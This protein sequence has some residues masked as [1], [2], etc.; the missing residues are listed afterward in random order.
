MTVMMTPFPIY[1]AVYHSLLQA[2][3]GTADIYRRMPTLCY[4]LRRE[5]VYIQRELL[6]ADFLCVYTVC[7]GAPQL[8]V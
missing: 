2:I 4:K 5:G 8:S 3:G 7:S 1:S 6:L